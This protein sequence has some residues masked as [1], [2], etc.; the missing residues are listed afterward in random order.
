[1]RCLS[2][3]K[4]KLLRALGSIQQK[5]MKQKKFM[6]KDSVVLSPFLKNFCH[7]LQ[8][9]PFLPTPSKSSK[10]FLFLQYPTPHP[11]IRISSHHPLENSPIICLISRKE[12]RSPTEST[13]ENICDVFII[14]FSSFVQ[15]ILHC[16]LWYNFFIFCRLFLMI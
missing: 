6:N 7:S 10:P 16:S 11:Q 4:S 9:L 1:M 15:F 3:N 5:K 13:F 14:I 12:E 8:F 2:R